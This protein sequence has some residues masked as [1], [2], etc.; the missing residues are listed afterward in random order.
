MADISRLRQPFLT[1]RG[2]SAVLSAVAVAIALVVGAIVLLNLFSRSL[3]ASFDQTLLVHAQDRARLVDS[4]TDPGSLTNLLQEEALVWI[5]TLDGQAISV[6]N[7]IVPIENPVPSKL[8]GVSTVSFTAE[9]D[10][11]GESEIEDFT[12]RVASAVVGD[13]SLVVLVGA[14]P[15]EIGDVLGRLRG[16]FQAAIPVMVLLVAGLAWLS[17]GRALRSVENIRRRTAEISG[18]TLAGRVPVPEGR[19]EIHDLAITMNAMLARVEAHELSL[20]QFTA[21]ASHE[22][23]SPL[24]NLRALIDTA[25]VSDAEWDVLKPRLVTESE[26]LRNLVDNLLFLATHSEAAPTRTPT[27]VNLDDLVFDEA[28]ILS[29]TKNISVNIDNVGPATVLGHR[30]DLARLVRNLTDNAARHAASSVSLSATTSQEG[31]VVVEVVDDGP[32]IA[33]Q[34]A[35]QVFE[36]FVRLDDARARSDGGA[37]LGLSIVKQIVE[38]HGATIEIGETL[39]GGATV[40]VRFPPVPDL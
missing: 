4:G 27:I 31:Q 12:M 34:D 2:R 17:A 35:S 9:V 13:G 18:S 10:H 1:V 6:G 29:A 19:D 37:G 24:A 30:A 32:G 26:R 25:D 5:G 38:D 40:V 15:E 28:E 20:R 3:Q 21:D 36:R 16:L 33:K 39:G 14:E 8:G 7:E 11:D 22:L 23:K